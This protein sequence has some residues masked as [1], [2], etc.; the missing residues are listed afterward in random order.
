MSST[1]IASPVLPGIQAGRLDAEQYR[2]NF[3]DAHPP[4]TLA[5]ARIEAERCYYCFEAPCQAA[6]PTGIDIPSFIQRIADDN[7]R[8]SASAILE[9]A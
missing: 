9:A 2:R 8:G 3:C 4:L 6:C 5:Q 7:I 1:D